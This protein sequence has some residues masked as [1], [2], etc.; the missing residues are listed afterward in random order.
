MAEAT[1]TLK[2]ESESPRI[3]R[4]LATRP[5]DLS[6]VIVTWNSERWIDR[7]LQSIAGACGGLAYE[8]IV[9]DNASV[10]ATLSAIGNGVDV[11]R[12]TAN[13][14]F[15]A[16]VNRVA[17]RA[18]G[19]YFFL[20]NPDCELAPRALE[21]LVEFLDANPVVAAAAPLLSDEAGDSQREFQL[22]RLP[23]LA[24]LVS[25]VFGIDKLFPANRMTARYRYR[26]LELTHPQPVEQP[27]AAA[28]LLRREV[29]AEVGPLDERFAPAWF[30]DVDYCRRLAAAGHTI[31]VVPA[32]RARHFGG[33]SLE[34][35]PFA[36]FIA[37]WYRN[38]WLYARKWL[39]PGQAE[40][41][42]WAIV[43]GMFLRMPLALLGIAHLHLGRWSAARAYAGVMRKAFKRWSGA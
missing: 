15:A 43:F 19:R 34:H 24:T 27:A 6:I 17:A 29:F 2:T 5:L 31:F 23:T 8:V 42:R 22:R 18:S 25:E 1:R 14:G 35:I 3:L 41:L 13:D 4:G 21:V 32:A 12:G 7:C 39:T 37:L 28:L 36:E 30:E 38:M 10:D 16:G 33:A 20:L 26:E 11:I 40:A 9:Y